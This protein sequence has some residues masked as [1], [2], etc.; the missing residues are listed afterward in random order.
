M[1]A[2][3]L[4]PVVVGADGRLSRV[5][6]E[7]GEGQMARA[8]LA[9]ALSSA[10]VRVVSGLGDTASGPSVVKVGDNDV[11][12]ALPAPRLVGCVPAGD[13][14]FPHLT[15]RENIGYGLVQLGES[16]AVTEGRVARVA[17]ALGLGFVLREKPY[18]TLSAAR[19]FTVA[20]ARSA[21]CLPEVLVVDLPASP[22]EPQRLERMLA[23]ARSVGAD[24]GQP[25]AVLVL[26][27][28]EGVAKAIAE[29]VHVKEEPY[30]GGEQPGGPP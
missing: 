2:L 20:V 16:H 11:T 13:S 30:P 28:D 4:D 14:L 15:V 9:P 3:H 22:M 24:G 10:V 6:L 23:S 5:T 8:E 21:A 1:A 29:D 17:E 18:D 27:E 12:E 7:L 25:M 26:S 19:R